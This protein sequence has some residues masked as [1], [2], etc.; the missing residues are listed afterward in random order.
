MV[1]WVAWV[2]GCYRLFFCTLGFEVD[3]ITKLHQAKPR[4]SPNKAQIYVLKL[5]H[6]PNTVGIKL[7]PPPPST[8]KL[9]KKKGENF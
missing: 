4:S 1:S 2:V 9:G 5:I 6:I 7:I 8:K 3:Q